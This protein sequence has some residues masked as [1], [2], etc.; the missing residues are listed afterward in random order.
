M[1]KPTG[2]TLIEL[3]IVVAIVGIILLIAIPNI[4]HR[5]DKANRIEELHSRWVEVCVEDMRKVDYTMSQDGARLRCE[6][7]WETEILPGLNQN[8][9]PRVQP[10]PVY[11]R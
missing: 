1:S 8:G 11:I 5:H 10:M 7:E 3:I 9:L 4:Y 2:F 6:L